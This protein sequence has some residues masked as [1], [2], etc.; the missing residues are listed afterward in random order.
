MFDGSPAIAI[1]FTQPLDRKQDFGA[2]VQATEGPLP[3]TDTD[4]DKAHRRGNAAADTSASAAAR[5][6]DARWVLGDNPRV[7]YLPYATPERQYRIAMHAGIA[8]A[9]GARLPVAQSCEVASESMPTSFYFA[10][11]GVVLPAEQN[12]GLPV[13]TVN[14]PEVDV[15]FLR[16]RPEAL[17]KFLEQV[18]GRR[19]RQVNANSVD[20]EE[21]DSYYNDYYDSGRKLKG[22]VGGYLLD[23]LRTLSDS[24]YIGRFATDARP[25]GRNVNFLP[26]EKIKEL[27]Q[28]GIYVAV[29]SQP[30]ASAGTTR[31]PT[32]T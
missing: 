23:E 24:I 17:P 18:G 1:S 25:N 21:G 3:D 9:S 22:T 5:P 16:I 19:D 6:L 10:S 14:V 26:V 32:T 8:A 4:T 20:A 2:L 28:P 12:G 11:R 31:S 30:A 29:M 7:L 15:Q 27:Q 13:I